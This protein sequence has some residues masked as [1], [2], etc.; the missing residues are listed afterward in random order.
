MPWTSAFAQSELFVRLQ[1]IDLTNKNS[2]DFPLTQMELAECLGLTP[3]HVN[4]MLK[5]LRGRELIKVEDRRVT[6][7]DRHA[8]EAVAEFNPNYLYLERKFR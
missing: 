5:E 4:R 2:Y 3:V 8:L 6:L 7:L 1:V